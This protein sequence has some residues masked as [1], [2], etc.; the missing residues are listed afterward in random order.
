VTLEQIREVAKISDYQRR[1][2]E[3]RN[4]EGMQIRSHNDRHD[5]KPG[6]YILVSLERDPVVAR[7]I[8]PQLR[9]EIF[10]RN[11]YTCQLC[12]AGA[13]D[14]D[15]FN[16]SRKLRLHIDHIVPKSQG[17]TDDKEN[18]RVL[19]SACNQGRSNI[20]TPSEDAMNLLARIRRQSRAVQREVYEKLKAF[21]GD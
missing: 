5:L 7:G 16:P 15:P 18:L 3:L 6:E 19:C 1:I 11:G 9:N 4:D 2:R 8:S 13:R 17:G 14:P 21:F 12:G 10:E 20:Q